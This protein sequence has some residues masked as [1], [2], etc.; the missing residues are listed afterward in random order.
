MPPPATSIIV[1]D[2]TGSNPLANAYCDVAYVDAYMTSVLYSDAWQNATPAQKEAAVI[3]ACRLIESNFQFNGYKAHP[4]Y[5]QPLQW[6]RA[7]CPNPDYP[8][9]SYG[10]PYYGQ[11]YYANDVIPV[12]LQDANA[13]EALD[14]L[15]QD[16][17]GSAQGIPV[18]IGAMSVADISIT[19]K[20]SVAVGGGA[21]GVMQFFPLSTQ[22]VALLDPLGVPTT[23]DGFA[24]VPVSRVM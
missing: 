22:C 23:G 20:D 11:V 4:D 12:C 19:Y 13:Q 15:R 24:S 18:G 8:Q 1:E 5:P 9:A 17:Y 16:W 3:N 6:P 7:Q 2:G 21:G 10:Y 14:L